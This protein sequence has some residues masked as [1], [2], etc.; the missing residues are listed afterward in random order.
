ML[1]SE[2]AKDTSNSVLQVYIDDKR[3]EVPENATILESIQ[4]AGVSVP[5]LCH[6]PRLK[7]VEA[8]RLWH[9]FVRS[10]A[11]CVG[12]TSGSVVEVSDD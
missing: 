3:V 12:V 1:K 11:S 7:P 9:L 4:V 8:C 10:G 5:S 6:D 2:A